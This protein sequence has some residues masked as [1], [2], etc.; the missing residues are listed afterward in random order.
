M[1][2]PDGNGND[3]IRDI[4]GWSEVPI[5]VLSARIDE[6][7]KVAALD[8]GAND[9]LT[10][11]FGVA[12]L[13]ARI[14]TALRRRLRVEDENKLLHLG[15]VVIDMAN[16]RITKNSAEIHLTQIEFRL[17]TA[18]L[19]HPGKVMTHRHL[20]REVWGPNHIEDSHYLRIYMG[21]LRQKLEDDPARPRYLITE[22]GIGYRLVC[23]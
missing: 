6:Q 13:M 1:G 10:K 16:R 18:L 9:Y 11:P 2:L 22:T 23:Q 3:F 8:A 4:R 7:D 5:I 14:R 12:E 19:N 15:N 20:L 17:L 21:H